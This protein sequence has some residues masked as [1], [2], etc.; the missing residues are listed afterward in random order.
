MIFRWCIGFLLALSWQLSA[1][2]MPLER[3]G[4][5]NVTIQYHADDAE[6]AQTVADTI[7]QAVAEFGV[8]LPLGAA[9][10]EIRLAT[11]M[12]EFAR[13][14]GPLGLAHVGGVAHSSEGRI[15]L[16]SPRL[17]SITEDFA[18][19]VRHE[20]VH[21]LLYRNADTR[22]LPRWLNEGT[23]MMLANEYRWES[24][25]HVARLV[26][27]NSLQKPDRLDGA[28]A[29]P[30]HEMAFGNAYAQGLSMTRWLRNHLGEENFWAVIRGTREF[31]FDEALKH[32][33]GL[34]SAAFWR[35]YRNSL[36]LVTLVGTLAG[37]SLFGPAAVLV[38][39]GYWRLRRKNRKILRRWAAEE[40]IEGSE[41][42]P[43][44]PY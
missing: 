43:W 5:K 7:E 35:G 24:N 41:Q 26:L 39:I 3:L 34:E 12:E 16:K 22:R 29:L 14:A 6:A 4:W 38:V 40:G 21:I 42:H 30:G 11:S 23:A 33:G 8:E 37:G 44:P 13:L 32:F 15:L 27:T 10:V 1:E 17:R 25:F 31:P 36:W 19:T 20:L 18:G 9:P 28:F 2:E